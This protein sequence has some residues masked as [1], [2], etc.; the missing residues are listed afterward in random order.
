MNVNT[1]QYFSEVP[2]LHSP[3]SVFDRSFTHKTT[4][5]VN[6]LYPI[7]IDEGLPGDS[8]KLDFQVFGRLINPLVV[9][10]MDEL[11]FETLWF[12]SY[13]LILWDNARR[14]FGER[15]NPTDDNDFV[16][17]T[18]N[19]GAGFAVGSIFDHFGL[20]VN[21]ANLDVNSLPLR[22]YNMVYNYWLRDQNLI[23]SV[24]FVK[25]DSDDISYY[26]L[27]KS[28]KMHDL[29]TSALPTTQING[30]PFGTGPVSLP[31]G[32]TAPVIGNG[33]PVHLTDGTNSATLS[34]GY[35]VSQ[36]TQA[37][38]QLGIADPSVNTLGGTANLTSWPNTVFNK[39]LGVSND[40]T[41]S[42]LIADLSEVSG[43]NVNDLRFMIDLQR[44]RER[45]M[46]GGHRYNEIVTQFFGIETYNE[47]YIPEFLGMTR[48]MIDINTVIQ[49]SSTDNTSPQG[50]LTAY[51]VINHHKSALSTS[52]RFHGYLLGLARIRHN[53]VYQQGLNKLWSRSTQLD[54]YNPMFN[55]LGEQP[56]KNKE[57]VCQGG[58]VLDAN[59]DPVDDN[60]FGFNEAWYE[61]RYYPSLITGQLRSGIIDSLDVYH[62]AQYF[63]TYTT[64]VTSTGTVPIGVPT[65]PVLNQ[66]FIEEN[67]P[68]QRATAVTTGEEENT[69]SFV[70]DFRFNY[71]CARVMP[72]RNIPAGLY[73]GI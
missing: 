38:P 32:G 8:M 62:L 27:L 24:T 3:R 68:L 64:T 46:L 35:S 50:N 42:G 20:P 69:P 44:Y 43:I 60:A 70:M 67:I 23:N 57:I 11:Y 71:T 17:P 56:I 61:Y 22:M 5:D 58:S 10:V 15:D 4:M 2:H 1:E 21:V 53:P 41:K 73:S 13:M 9:P 45:L 36:V 7:F 52:F 28:A 55:G 14:F 65:L 51:G 54:F 49:T 25:T 59:G 16:I 37:Y 26:S 18:I 19:S 29:F 72:V 31:I 66:S 34:S 47:P 48:E 40:S 30:T 33:L 39:A 63:G 12:K 6:K